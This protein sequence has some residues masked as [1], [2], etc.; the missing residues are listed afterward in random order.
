MIHTDYTQNFRCSAQKAGQIFKVSIRIEKSEK[1][2]DH[3]SFYQSHSRS[4]TIFF[5]DRTDY[6]YLLFCYILYFNLVTKTYC[7]NVPQGFAPLPTLLNAL[8]TRF[9]LLERVWELLRIWKRCTLLGSCSTVRVRYHWD[10]LPLKL[11]FL[12]LN[13]LSQIMSI[14]SRL[15]DSD[16]SQTITINQNLTQYFELK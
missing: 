4:L 8:D 11:I 14:V 6:F 9:S 7:N 16:I 15:I 13:N 2:G 3:I 10:I 12:N 5:E 1:M